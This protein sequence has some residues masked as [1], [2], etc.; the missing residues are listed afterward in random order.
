LYLIKIRRIT[1]IEK[2][3]IWNFRV[4]PQQIYSFDIL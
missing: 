2:F 3:S 4:F 1:K